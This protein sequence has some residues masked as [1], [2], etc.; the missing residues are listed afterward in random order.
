MSENFVPLLITILIGG[1]LWISGLWAIVGLEKLSR[2][3]QG[4]AYCK[5]C[6]VVFDI[7]ETN[8]FCPV[9]NRKRK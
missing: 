7:K 5:S 4:K 1:F 9:C 2:K 6:Q 8:G 3:L